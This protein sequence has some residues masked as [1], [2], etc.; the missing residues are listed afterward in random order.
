[1]APKRRF[2][3][4]RRALTSDPFPPNGCRSQGFAGSPEADWLLAWRGGEKQISRS[5]P[6]SGRAAKRPHDGRTERIGG[7][8]RADFPLPQ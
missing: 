7:S 4:G 3:E 8:P 1:M 5:R 2:N 6:S